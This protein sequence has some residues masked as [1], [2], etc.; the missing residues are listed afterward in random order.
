MLDRYA[1]HGYR[2]LAIA[3]KFVPVNQARMAK[4]N[5]MTRAEMESD[6]TFLGLIVLENRL[7]V[8]C[9]RIFL[10]SVLNLCRLEIVSV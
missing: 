7:K 6:L 1:S 4:I 2:I 10:G 3:C 8:Q 5:K 9:H